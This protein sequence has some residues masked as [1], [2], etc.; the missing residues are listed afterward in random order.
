MRLPRK[1]IMGWRPWRRTWVACIARLIRCGERCRSRARELLR[2]VDAGYFS[3]RNV[4]MRQ[5]VDEGVQGG[6]KRDRDGRGDEDGQLV[7]G[8]RMLGDHKYYALKASRAAARLHV[9]TASSVLRDGRAPITTAHSDT[10]QSF[11]ALPANS[12]HSR[13]TS[14]CAKP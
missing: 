9:S 11:L 6:L 3:S 8:T 4:W 14:P 12:A 1:R 2:R 10:P 13:L 5:M 7:E